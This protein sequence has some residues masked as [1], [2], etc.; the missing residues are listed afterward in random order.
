MN[1]SSVSH[2]EFG[3]YLKGRQSES[4]LECGMPEPF[5]GYEYKQGTPVSSYP[6]IASAYESRIRSD[7]GALGWCRDMFTFSCVFQDGTMQVYALSKDRAVNEWFSAVRL[8]TYQ[9]DST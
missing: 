1:I 3:V 6:A 5:R 4:V 9:R 2:L 8:L 7:V